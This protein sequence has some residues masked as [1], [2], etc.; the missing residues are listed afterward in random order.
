MFD[1]YMI[2]E[3]TVR[4]VSQDGRVTGFQFGARIAY[5]RGLG[6]SMVEGL[7]VSVDGEAVSPDHIRF[8]VGNRTFSLGEMETEYEARWE[9]GEVAT[10][11]VLRPGGLTAGE[12]KLEFTEDLRIAYMPFPL[13]GRDAKVV[14]IG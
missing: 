7:A 1:R 6:L 13:K 14:R 12:H 9:F 10:V 2:C 8:T 11:S 5:Y 3:E 4:N